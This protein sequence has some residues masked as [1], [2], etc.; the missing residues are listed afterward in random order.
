MTNGYLKKYVIQYVVKNTTG[1]MYAINV[2]IDKPNYKVTLK[3]TIF[4]TNIFDPN[5]K[6]DWK[7]IADAL[8]KDPIIGDMCNTT[9][10]HIADPKSISIISYKGKK[11]RRKHWYVLVDNSIVGMIADKIV[12]LNTY[13]K[14]KMPVGEYTVNS[15]DSFGLEVNIKM[16][17]SL[18]DFI[19]LLKRTH[20]CI[21]E[22]K[23]SGSV[24]K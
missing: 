2:S 6:L 19:Y 16:K 17:S 18:T 22:T 5:E 11:F 8:M 14:P 1:N 7:C 4:G 20:A 15:I 10:D 23:Y 12:S 13:A 24:D 3:S 9:V 21:Q